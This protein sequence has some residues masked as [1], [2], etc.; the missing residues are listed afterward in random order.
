MNITVLG[1]GAW[2]T[3]I[4]QVLAQNGHKVIMWCYHKNCAQEIANKQ[5]NSQFI[6]NI[7]VHTNVTPITNLQDAVANSDVV[8]EAIPVKY[9]RSVL[10]LTKQYI[11][12]NQIWVTLSKGIETKTLLLPTQMID[13]V[14]NMKVQHVVVSGPS[15]A[16]DLLYKQPTGVTVASVDEKAQKMV[17]KLLQNNYFKMCYSDDILGAQV[18]GAIKNV[19]ALGVG[20]LD[21]AGYTDNTKAL[22]VTQSLQE[23][24]TITVY[25]GGKPE[26]VYELCGIGDL[27]L[28]ALGARSRNLLIGKRLSAGKTLETI[29]QEHGYIPEGIT[30]VQ[31]VHELAQN[32][33]LAVPICSA[34]Y[35]IIFEKFSVQMLIKQV[36][37]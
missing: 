7:Q 33:N 1:E 36:V 37:T 23:F 21:G 9:L 34:I 30:T 25:F 32:N 24:K 4:A 27:M 19:I 22:L 17:G 14:F 10:E 26:T 11:P 5:T 29:I 15:F 28:T 12:A 18:T 35:S 16:H 3:A 8:F 13:D 6:S 2:G 31:S 20:I